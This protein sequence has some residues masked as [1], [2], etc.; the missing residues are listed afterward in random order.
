MKLP[1]KLMLTEF[2]VLMLQI[3]LHKKQSNYLYSKGSEIK[4]IL[5]EWFKKLIA[6]K[7]KNEEIVVLRK[8]KLDEFQENN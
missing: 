8:F 4:Q 7:M 5:K 1:L 2:Q 6:I 3:N